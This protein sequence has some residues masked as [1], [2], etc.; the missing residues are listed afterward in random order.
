MPLTP[1]QRRQLAMRDIV[2]AIDGQLAIAN[3]QTVPPIT[4]TQVAAY[5]DYLG[6][7]ADGA[8][9]DPQVRPTCPAHHLERCRSACMDDG[10]VA[11]DTVDME[12]GVLMDAGAEF[13]PD[14]TKPYPEQE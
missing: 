3:T 2:A 4:R 13:D 7:K 11:L 14:Y 10:G 9:A 12:F 5:L 1:Q 8:A 6:Y